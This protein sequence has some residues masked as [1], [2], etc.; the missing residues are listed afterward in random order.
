MKYLLYTNYTYAYL[1]IEQDVPS[2]EVQIIQNHPGK[3]VKD[4]SLS[5]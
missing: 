4:K 1:D 5:A 3:S 2:E